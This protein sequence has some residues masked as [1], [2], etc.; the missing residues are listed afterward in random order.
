MV[1]ALVLAVARLRASLGLQSSR[2]S[3][4]RRRRPSE[5]TWPRQSAAVG[6]LLR[7]AQLRLRM[8]ACTGLS[9]R[10]VCRA[11][12][13][14]WERRACLLASKNLGLEARMSFGGDAF[15][16]VERFLVCSAC[17]YVLPFCT[18]KGHL[19]VCR[20]HWRRGRRYVSMV[21]CSCRSRTDGLQH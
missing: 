5:R 6:R 18:C 14:H 3:A 10:L 7:R 12:R 17:V 9:C 11:C 21:Y 2:S 1:V 13:L 16:G 20:R 4:W 19:F 15:D 8:R